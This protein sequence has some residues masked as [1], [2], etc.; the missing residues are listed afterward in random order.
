MLD[1]VEVVGPS[2]ARMVVS[3]YHYSRVM[4]RITRFCVGGWA[5]NRLVAVMTLGFG[6]RPRYTI[7]GMF[8]SLGTEDYLEIGKLCVAD[9]MPR[10]TESY[11]ISRALRVVRE[12]R[13]DLSLVFSWADGILGKPGY[14]Y[15]AA[16]FFYGGYI[17]TEVYL[18]A[19]GVKVHPRTVQGLTAREGEVRGPR[20]YETTSALGLTK[21]FGKQFRYVYPLCDKRKWQRLAAESPYEWTRGNYPKDADCTYRQQ[22]GKGNIVD[23]KEIPFVRGDSV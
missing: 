19:N 11:F 15:Q 2:L 1:S 8:P 14:V 21:Y 23:C 12:I 10:N 5:S 16:N 4:P 20:D 6:T 3:Q 9:E 17:W 18:T 22:V 13:P 7:Q